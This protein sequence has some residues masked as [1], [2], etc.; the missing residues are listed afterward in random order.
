MDREP[1][2]LNDLPGINSGAI[3]T[4]VTFSSLMRRGDAAVSLTITGAPQLDA[5]LL[6]AALVRAFPQT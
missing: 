6:F 3:I 2:D 5:S 4:A 1:I